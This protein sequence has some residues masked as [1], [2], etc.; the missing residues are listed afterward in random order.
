MMEDEKSTISTVTPRNSVPEFVMPPPI[1]RDE[2][3]H[4]EKAV[5][6]EKLLF[7]EV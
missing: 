5:K 7:I 2:I 6:I 3:R 4:G 1:N